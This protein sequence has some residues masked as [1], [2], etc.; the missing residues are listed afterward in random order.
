MAK[1]PRVLKR[2][3]HKGQFVKYPSTWRYRM[4]HTGKRRFDTRCDLI[5]GL[6]AC[7]ERHTEEEP[8]VREMLQR[9]NCRIESHAEWL[10]RTRAEE[11]ET[12]TT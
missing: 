3:G 5:V 4:V 12:L 11:P 10:E 9:E 6:C 2:F 7:G 8:W 1:P